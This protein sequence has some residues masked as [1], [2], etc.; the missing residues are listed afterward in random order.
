VEV[1]K[2][3][4]P[5]VVLEFSTKKWWDHKNWT[6]VKKRNI[7][8]SRRNRHKVYPVEILNYIL[9]SQRYSKG[10]WTQGFLE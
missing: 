4:A 8:Y 9:L 2:K 1:I 3:D 7:F 10:R 5:P 6:V